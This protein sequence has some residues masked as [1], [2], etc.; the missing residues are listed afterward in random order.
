MNRVLILT[1]AVWL[2]GMRRRVELC[3][4]ALPA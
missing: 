2:P 4:G 1:V 3:R